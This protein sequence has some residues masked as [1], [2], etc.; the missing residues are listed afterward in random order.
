MDF[1]GLLAVVITLTAL[2]SYVNHRWLRLPRAIGLLL[3]GLGVSGVLIGIGR[4]FPGFQRSALAT[5]GAVDF[6]R[7]VLHG[8]L[9]AGTVSAT[10]DPSMASG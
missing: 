1:F 7:L 6:D 4:S 10:T 3:M 5:V 9:G 2:F 8:V